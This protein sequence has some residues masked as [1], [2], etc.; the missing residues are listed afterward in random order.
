MNTWTLPLISEWAADVQAK[1]WFVIS[2][3]AGL[4]GGLTTNISPILLIAV[5]LFILTGYLLWHTAFGLRVRSCGEN[6]WAAESLGVHVRFYKYIAVITSG[7]LAGLG[8][9]YL[10]IVLAG[11]YREGQT[12]GRGFIGLAAMIFGNWRPAGTALGSLLFGY[13]DALQLRQSET[14]RA[15]ILLG[16]I[17]MI[18]LA[19][20]LISR[21][22]ASGGMAVGVVG[23]VL[24][25]LYLTTEQVPGQLAFIAPYVT[26]L[27]VLALASQS[28]RMPAA[29]GVR[30]RPGED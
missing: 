27:L 4:I 12:G 2:D 15:L 5:A 3:V 9:A 26:T 20:W 25:S 29:D 17:V 7:G 21:R 1:G 8:G 19:F 22:R 14:V 13:V 30:Y 18:G 23:A 10:A 24:L 6:P 28:L 11:I 16:A